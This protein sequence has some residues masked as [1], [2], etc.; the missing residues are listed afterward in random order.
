MSSLDLHYLATSATKEERSQISQNEL[1]EIHRANVASMLSALDNELYAATLAALQHTDSYWDYSSYLHSNQPEGENFSYF[2]VRVR[3][4]EERNSLG[5]AWQ[6]RYPVQG[7]GK[8]GRK[9]NSR[10]IAKGP[11]YQ[12][13]KKSFGQ[14]RNWEYE[15]IEEAENHFGKIRQHIEAIGKLRKNIDAL[16]RLIE[17]NFAS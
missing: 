7:R 6:K 15:A 1:L 9:T 14:I 16:G 13:T 12:H 10:H 5:I 4:D 8:S 17:K 3:L 2:S 11:G